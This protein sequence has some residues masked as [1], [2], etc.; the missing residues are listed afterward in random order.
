MTPTGRDRPYF[1]AQLGD[2]VQ[3]NLCQN[4]PTKHHL[5]GNKLLTRYHIQ[6]LATPPRAMRYD[7]IPT[8]VNGIK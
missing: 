7:P 8:P 2:P 6:Q 1:A 5:E 3:S 4:Q